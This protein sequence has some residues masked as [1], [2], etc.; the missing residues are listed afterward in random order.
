MR[1]SY[2]TSDDKHKK[3]KY[4]IC[5]CCVIAVVVWYQHA[6]SSDI[7]DI[8]KDC[9]IC[10][11]GHG[12]T[13]TVPGRLLVKPVPELCTGCHPQ[14]VGTNEH[15]IGMK[16]SMEIPQELSLDGQGQVTCITCHSP[17]GKE[18]HPD[19]LRKPPAEICQA[20]H[21]T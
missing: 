21:N 6:F 13:D 5:F 18:G 17:H 14:R 4:A 19:M 11:G 8:K 12:M 2:A 1:L 3:M 15:P 20:C 7:P 9:T 10:H 16:P